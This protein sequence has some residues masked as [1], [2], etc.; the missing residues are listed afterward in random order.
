M[1]NI[2]KFQMINKFKH[3]EIIQVKVN[4]QNKQII[5]IYNTQDIRQQLNNLLINY[6]PLTK[7]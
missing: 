4:K 5:K 3:Q 7:I 1:T 2:D 6:H